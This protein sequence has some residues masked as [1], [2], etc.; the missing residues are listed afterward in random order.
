MKLNFIKRAK[1]QPKV[2]ALLFS[3]GNYSS[4]F[5][6]NDGQSVP[7]EFIFRSWVTP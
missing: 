2:A 1:P 7:L 6:N 3:N 4:I 5:H